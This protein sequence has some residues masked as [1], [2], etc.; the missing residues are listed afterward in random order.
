MSSSNI[1]DKPS[2]KLDF[3]YQV[4]W[5]WILSDPL[6]TDNMVSKVSTAMSA[7]WS[8]QCFPGFTASLGTEASS[9]GLRWGG[10]GGKRETIKR[11]LRWHSKE[12]PVLDDE[13]FL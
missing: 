1:S 11:F 3:C 2:V 9:L 5:E 12:T 8:C 4:C 7:A 10:G 6:N 13:V